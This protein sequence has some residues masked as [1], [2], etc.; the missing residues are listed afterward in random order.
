MGHGDTNL[1]AVEDFRLNLK[2][3]LDYY[4]NLLGHPDYLVGDLMDSISRQ[5]LISNRISPW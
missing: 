3:C 1:K 2:Q 4:D 5:A